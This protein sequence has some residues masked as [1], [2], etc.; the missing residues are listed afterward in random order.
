MSRGEMMLALVVLLLSAC[1]GG[2]GSDDADS[3]QQEAAQQDDDN[4]NNA[5]ESPTVPDLIP[6]IETALI[7]VWDWSE[8]YGDAGNDEVYLVV[9]Q[10][11]RLSEYDYQGDTFSGGNNCYAISRHWGRFTR[12]APNYLYSEVEVESKLLVDLEVSNGDLY[13][14]ALEFN[15]AFPFEVGERLLFGVGLRNPPVIAEMD[16]MECE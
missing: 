13:L 1:G 7:G 3:N 2:G 11:G 16:A 12:S 4:T 15:E 10:Q 9:D 8:D 6:D 14:T 5:G